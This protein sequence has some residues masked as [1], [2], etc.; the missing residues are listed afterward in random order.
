MGY[1]RW[2][3]ASYTSYSSARSNMASNEIFTGREIDSRMDLQEIES[4]EA[5]DSDLNPNSTPII[6][7]I[8]VTGSMGRL[9]EY[10]V[11][12]GLGVMVSHILERRPV[13]DPAICVVA[14]GDAEH[15][16]APIQ[17]GQFES[18]LAITE[19]LEAIFIEG[20]GG[21]NN[22]ESYDLPYY[23]AINKTRTDSFEIRN[24][25]GVIITIGDELPND[26]LRKEHIRQFIG[27]TPEVDL[28]FED[29]ISDIRPMYTPYHIIIAEGYFASRSVDRVKD[30]WRE[31]LGNAAMVL[32]DHRKAAELIVSML[33]VDAGNSVENA[34]SIW[35]QDTA[36]ILRESFTDFV[37]SG[38]A[39]LSRRMD[40]A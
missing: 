21:G 24:E 6:I 27:D 5:R 10:L 20:G 25:P 23:F 30:A 9:A 4:R 7:G 33:E 1:S 37:S 40:A 35:D 19:W 34:I 17:V 11:K 2:D 18:D 31:Y 39:R 36:R 16:R 38:A 29:L 3:N 14:I 13:V 26:V 22:H 32:N 8:D 12:T 28:R 15:D